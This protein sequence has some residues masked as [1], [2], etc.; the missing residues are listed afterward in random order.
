M[1]KTYIISILFAVLLAVGIF[2]CTSIKNEEE[3]SIISPELKAQIEQVGIFHNQGLDAVLVD[4]LKETRQLTAE[5][6]FSKEHLANYDFN[7]LVYS[8]TRRMVKN[9]Y[10]TLN[11]EY[12]E[13]VMSNPYLQR[14]N[15]ST[16]S[17][18]DEN[19][20][21]LKEVLSPFQLEY[22][23]KLLKIVN[24]EGITL[25]RLK[26]EVLILEAQIEKEAPSVSE[27]EVLLCATSVARYSSEYW[28]QNIDV[29]A[30][31]LFSEMED[32]FDKD[33][34]TRKWSW[35][36]FAKEDIVGAVSGAI[37]GAAAGFFLGGISVGAGLLAGGVSVGVCNSATYALG[38]LWDWIW[39]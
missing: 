26:A 35:N 17:A 39:N 36:L 29:W 25:D 37:G 12:L 22:Y 24:T 10:P 11:D 5:S 38:Q 2:A 13:A 32:S 28:E 34:E 19:E 27:A 18:S 8:T 15:C 21:D 23:N 16:R 9:W 30:T 1:K 4:L 20:Q 14:Y 31:V 6:H 7:T 33:I 3:E